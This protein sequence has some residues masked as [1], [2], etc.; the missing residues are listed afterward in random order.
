[1]FSAS[2]TPSLLI[3][4][5]D[6]RGLQEQGLSLATRL[7]DNAEARLGVGVPT[8]GITHLAHWTETHLALSGT[9][10]ETVVL[11]G[12]GSRS[13]LRLAEDAAGLTPWGLI[14]D[15]LRGLRP[16]RLV[17]I[18]GPHPRNSDPGPMFRA[19]PT[20]Q[21]IVGA[22]LYLDEERLQKLLDCL[23][24]LP[25]S[26][27]ALGLQRHRRQEYDTGPSGITGLRMAEVSFH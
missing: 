22:S 24:Y 4:E 11:I 26:V 8:I 6:T 10:A 16:L 17:V 3:L 15:R 5:C 21:E 14:A 2:L 23:P 20:L 12:H 27:Q 25:A 13:G 7:R 19:M 18:A 1:M 9:R